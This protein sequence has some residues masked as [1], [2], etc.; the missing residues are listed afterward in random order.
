MD[1]VVSNLHSMYKLKS[2]VFFTN[3]DGDLTWG[4]VLADYVV[5]DVNAVTLAGLYLEAGHTYHVN[6][7]P[8]HPAGCYTV[9][10]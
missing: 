9:L 7:Q 8:C 3:S 2:F 6:L 4:Q 1:Y 5:G 10:L